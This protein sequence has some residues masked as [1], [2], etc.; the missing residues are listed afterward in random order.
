MSQE[1]PGFSDPAYRARRIPEVR[2]LHATDC[3]A[4][5]L[6]MAL[7][8][9][10][11]DVRLDEVREVMG[12]GRDGVS[13]MIA[14]RAGG[15]YEPELA[16]VFLDHADRLLAGL[17]EP[18]DREIILALEPQPH[19]LLDEQGCEEAYLALADM[20]DMR[21][22]FTFG[23]SRAVA[24]LA[25]AA[26]TQMGLPASDVRAVRWAAYIVGFGGDKEKANTGD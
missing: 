3:G 14:K 9:H 26:A 21:M 18:V 4:A 6:A 12:I 5:C 20:I 17:G 8:Y 11:R 10:G 19:A 13:A 23:H 22:P 16:Q 15:A 25:G 7:G 24:A 1:H 2:Q